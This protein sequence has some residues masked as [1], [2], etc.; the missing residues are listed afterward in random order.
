M[1]YNPSRRDFLK[2]LGLGAAAAGCKTVPSAVDKAIETLVEEPGV[3][4]QEKVTAE[5]NATI[6]EVKTLVDYIKT[7]GE[8][9]FNE[10]SMEVQHGDFSFKIEYSELKGDGCNQLIINVLNKG[11]S[12]VE[13]LDQYLD[14]YLRDTRDK[15]NATRTFFDYVMRIGADCKYSPQE[16]LSTRQGGFSLNETLA[17]QQ[18]RFHEE[19][20]LKRQDANSKYRM[21][22]KDIIGELKK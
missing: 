9:G 4:S 16:S 8:K 2:W 7:Y 5:R 21:V 13:F 11:E 1:T 15:D 3:W 22:L 14:G 12:S 20:S 10:Y 17:I 19:L 18:T 6:R